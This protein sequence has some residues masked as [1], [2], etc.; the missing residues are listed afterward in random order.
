MSDKKTVVCIEDDVDLLDLVERILREPNVETYGALGAREGLAFV[1]SK[2][3]DLVLLDLYLPGMSG[4]EVYRRIRSDERLKDTPIIVVSACHAKIA[5]ALGHD[6]S[7]V[8]DYISK[9]FSVAQ[10]RTSVDRALGIA[11]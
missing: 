11:L 4:W 7:G 10:L 9:P 5:T 6:L 8:A 3:P 1:Q 2:K